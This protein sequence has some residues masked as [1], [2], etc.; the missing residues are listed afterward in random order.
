MVRR[1]EGA[2]LA[3]LAEIIGVADDEDKCIL[4]PSHR[5]TVVPPKLQLI[6]N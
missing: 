1:Y 3:S 4:V 6:E 2:R 5:R